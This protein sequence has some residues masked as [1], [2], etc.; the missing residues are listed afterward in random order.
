MRGSRV[1][2]RRLLVL[3]AIGAVHLYIWEG[4]ILFLYA[5]VGFLPDSLP[6]VSRPTLLRARRS[7]SSS[8]PS[9]SRRS[10]SPAAG[11]STPER[12]CCARPGGARRDRICPGD[13]P[14]FPMLR[15]AGW[16]EYLRFQLSGVFFRYADLLTTGRPFK[17]LAM[18]L[19][20]SG[21][22]ARACCRDL[23]PWL[24]TL[25]RVRRW[26]FASDFRPPA[27]ASGADGAAGFRPPWLKVAESLV[28]ARR[29]AAGAGI[30]DDVRDPLAISQL[31]RATHTP[32]ARW[33][34]GADELPVADRCRADG[35]LRHRVRS[36]GPGRPVLV[37]APGRDRDHGAGGF[38]PMVAGTLCVR[39]D[40]VDLAPGDLPTAPAPPKGGIAARVL[41]QNQ[42][43]V[44][45]VVRVIRGP[46]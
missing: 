42:I 8:R 23:T 22:D 39:P 5:L 37:A 15:D 1:F 17:V 4:D 32:R 33:T 40:G 12:R 31:A 30:R 11:R 3:L 29:R 27:V 44:V 46:R 24:P 18:F 7:R 2:R 14:P 9:R 43:R 28:R 6:A 45:R 21:S 26:G 41:S 16:A 38:Q 34:H 19:V 36:D 10:S 13:A 20:G 25:R 35:V